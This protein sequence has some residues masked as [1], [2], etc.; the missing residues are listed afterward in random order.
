MKI[1][2]LDIYGYGKWV[3]QSFKVDDQLQLFYGQ[4]EAGKS[5]LQSFIRSM[6]FGF[7]NKRRSVNQQKRYEPR[8][9][10]VYGGRLLLADT[11]YG[12]I[13]V[14]RTSKRLTVS[15]LDGTE[16]PS[17]ALDEV[18]GGLDEKLFDNF[19]AFTLQN[20]QEL[21]NIGADQLNDYFMSIGTVGSD[22]FL[23]I[24]KQYQKET[25]ELYR[26]NGQSRPLNQLLSEYDELAQNIARMQQ[27]MARY[28]AL[29]AQRAEEEAKIQLLNQEVKQ[30]EQDLREMDKLVG[31]YDIYLKDRAAKRELEQLVYT[32][33]DEEQVLTLREALKLNQA[34]EIQLVQ[35]DERIRNLNGELGSLTKLNW[36]RN[37][38]SARQEWMLA[39]ARV[40][41][42]QTVIEQLTARIREQGELM[43]QLAHQ[44]QFFPEKIAAITDY[45]TK[46]AEGLQL[47]MEKEELLKQLEMMKAERKV[48]LEQR[49]EQQNYTAVVRQQIV[50]LEHQRMNEEAQL[51]ELTK[52]NR[53][54]PG[55]ACLVVG[56]IMAIPQ[57][58]VQATSLMFWVGIVLAV[59]G[60]GSI[61]YIFNLNRR[62]YQAFYGSPVIAKIQELR[63]KETQYHEQ[64][65]SLGIQINQREEAV[66]QLEGALHEIGQQQARWLAQIGFYPTADP[67][68]ILK[69][70]PVKHY[71]AAQEQK[72][73]LEAQKEALQAQIVQWRT[74]VQPLFERF[75][76]AEEDIRHQIRHVEEQEVSL[77]RTV[78][79]GNVMDQRIQE[80]TEQMAAQHQLVQEREQQI[81]AIFAATHSR[82]EMDFFQKVETN[83]LIEE[84]TAKRALYQEQMEGY[85]EALAQVQTKQTLVESYHRLEHQV[86]VMKE[87]LVPH[88]RQRADLEVEIRHL[89]QDGTY[90]EQL[91]Q[92]A[93]KESQIRDMIGEWGRKRL[94]ME[95]IHRT[96]RQGMDNP[97]PEL[98]K[99]ADELFE[100]LS[101]GRY[102]QI[103]L[104]KN[105]IKVRQFS[106]IYFEPHELSQGTLEQLYVAL[107]IAFVENVRTM[108]KMP[109]IID[110]AFVNFDEHRKAS[111][112]RVLQQISDRIQILFFT[113]DQQA[114]QFFANN[115]RIDLDRIQVTLPEAVGATKEE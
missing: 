9:N 70:N 81:Q 90:Q 7:P 36:A 110:D 91:Q 74:L 25:D 14:E 20:L 16:L 5:T 26:P 97:L 105:G 72:Q 92:L 31:R 88:H 48:Y 112:Y 45:D 104:N 57:F 93:M 28:D 80:A 55:L 79:R 66:E 15:R 113:F 111:M 84:L 109:I 42:T 22:Q 95:L 83:Q 63:E 59:V 19:Y 6:L 38:E 10:E 53:Y 108:V 50:H 44:G 115:Q 68:L 43:T 35:L 107:R 2:Q 54:L 67:E 47:Q 103:K 82:D 64:S 96:L 46:L 11:K 75:P 41:E 60:V 52:L 4:N 17:R 69:A 27:N 98:N 30:L 13:W 86:E 101:Y 18:L 51:M 65:K 24:A 49:K 85:E 33:I 61:G 23:K 39:T 58:L 71:V 40:K 37:H 76:L 56:L 32:E 8:H 34:S 89:E 114:E 21:S 29:L 100:T 73:E 12:D 62:R 3:N 87:R 99:L 78:E 102:T 1:K 94:A 106:D 77:V